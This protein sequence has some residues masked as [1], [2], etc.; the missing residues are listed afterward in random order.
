[1][2]CLEQIKNNLCYQNLPVRLIGVGGGYSYGPF[3]VT[4]QAIEDIAIMR[5]LPNM[6]VIAPASKREMEQLAPQIHELKGP[7]YIRISNTD[8]AVNYTNVP[9]AKLGKALEILPGNEILL[10]ATSNA[11]DNAFQVCLNLKKQGIDAGL[12]SVHTLKPF[13]HEYLL[14]KQQNLRAIF[15]I[16]EHSII[17]GLGQATAH[18][19]CENFDKKIIFKAFGV[20]DIYPNEI[21]SRKYLQEKAGL[22]VENI[23]TKILSVLNP[24]KQ[25]LCQT[26]K[27]EVTL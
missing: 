6:T 11:L 9:T 1:M 5:A 23:C 26:S 14:S 19:I 17:G 18:V 3:G 27:H 21:G 16:E 7:V 12:A 25:T 22:S 4:H 2:R 24:Q 8:E 10:L 20:N 13:D 15:T